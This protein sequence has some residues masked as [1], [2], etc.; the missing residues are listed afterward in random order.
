MDNGVVRTIE[1]KFQQIFRSCSACHRIGHL[2]RTCPHTAAQMVAG[3]EQVVQRAFDRFCTRFLCSF[4]SRIAELLWQDWIHAH[5]TRGSTKI[6]FARIRLRYSVFETLPQDVLFQT[7]R[8]EG[9]LHLSDDDIS[10]DSIPD[11]QEATGDGN[12]AD[13]F[14]PHPMEDDLEE[15]MHSPPLDIVTNNSN[16]NQ[17][18]PNYLAYPHT[19]VPSDDPIQ[20]SL[21]IQPHIPHLVN[22]IQNPINITEDPLRNWSCPI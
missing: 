13:D 5:R 22:D 18:D 21:N 14:D 19:L 16:E 9:I 20:L 15:N 1:C 4:T 6:R 3:F 11:T 7:D 8:F 17:D 2:V 12:L 10:D